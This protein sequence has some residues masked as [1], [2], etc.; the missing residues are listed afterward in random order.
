MLPALVS[1]LPAA[2]AQAASDRVDAGAAAVEVPTVARLLDTEERASYTPLCCFVI[3]RDQ[4]SDRHEWATPQYD[5]E[6]RAEVV[7]VYQGDTHADATARGATYQRLVDIACSRI[8]AA[9]TIAG[10]WRIAVGRG[11]REPVGTDKWR[12]KAGHEVTL[13]TR[14]TREE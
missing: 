12:R 13:W 9:G 7:V 6:I 1:A 10:V 8:G 4:L 14:V 5:D 2:L 3:P 11:V